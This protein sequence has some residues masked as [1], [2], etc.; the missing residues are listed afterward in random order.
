MAHTDGAA[1]AC[2]YC[3]GER[4]L[5]VRPLRLIADYTAFCL[6]WVGEPIDGDTLAMQLAKQAVFVSIKRA[7]TNG[8]HP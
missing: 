5:V 2:G 8:W 1:F 6:T 3:S 7:D 4:A